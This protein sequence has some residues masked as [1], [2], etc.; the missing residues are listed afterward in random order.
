MK[1]NSDKGKKSKIKENVFY[2]CIACGHVHFLITE[3][4]RSHIG[5]KKDIQ[6]T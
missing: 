4:G 6:K 5:Y 1:K 2:C 3:I